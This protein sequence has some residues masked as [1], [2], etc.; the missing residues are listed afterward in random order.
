MQSRS[1]WDAEKVSVKKFFFE[2]MLREN[3]LIFPVCVIR[4]IFI[5]KLAHLTISRPFFLINKKKCIK[6]TAAFE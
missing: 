3:L 4:N 2:T 6:T 5:R 1:Q